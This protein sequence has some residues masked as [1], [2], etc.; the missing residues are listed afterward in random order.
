M[1]LLADNLILLVVLC[2]VC[3]LLGTVLGLILPLFFGRL[4][5]EDRPERGFES[6]EADPTRDPAQ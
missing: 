3:F 1:T 4:R 5:L 6:C 2:S